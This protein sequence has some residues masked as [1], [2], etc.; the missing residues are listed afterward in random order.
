MWISTVKDL[1]LSLFEKAINMACFF[2]FR[3]SR[4]LVFIYSCKRI[5]VNSR[6]VGFDCFTVLFFLNLICSHFYL[7]IYLFPHSLFWSWKMKCLLL[8]SETSQ[9]HVAVTGSLHYPRYPISRISYHVTSMRGY[10]RN[11]SKSFSQEESKKNKVYKN[12]E[13]E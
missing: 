2:I 5:S 7:F 13:D 8:A 6:Y 9:T 4:S 11:D 1:S 12:F 10:I 3:Y